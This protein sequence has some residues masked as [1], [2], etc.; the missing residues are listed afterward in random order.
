AG[1]SQRNDS[2]RMQVLGAASGR[3]QARRR[4]AEEQL[5]RA[6]Q[7]PRPREAAMREGP[8]SV[9]CQGESMSERSGGEARAGGVAARETN[10]SLAALPPRSWPSVTGLVACLLLT[11][12]MVGPDFRQPVFFNDTPTTE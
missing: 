1:I 10:S 12:C 2:R 7:E 11:G 4:W 8:R 9:R 3:H 5:A 6:A